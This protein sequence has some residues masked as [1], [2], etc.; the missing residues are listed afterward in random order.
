MACRLP[1]A[2]SCHRRVQSEVHRLWQDG[3][4]LSQAGQFGEEAAAELVQAEAFPE[5]AEW[6]A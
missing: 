2:G 1:Q 6:A 4:R 5:I 3:Q